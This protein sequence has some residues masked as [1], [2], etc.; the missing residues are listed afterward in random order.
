LPPGA[1]PSTGTPGTDPARHQ[2]LCL[3][4]PQSANQRPLFVYWI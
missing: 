3:G 2:L 4:V 1:R